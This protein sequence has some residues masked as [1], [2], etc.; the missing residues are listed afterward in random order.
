MRRS[1][2]FL[3]TLLLLALTSCLKEET[4]SNLD[5]AVNDKALNLPATEGKTRILVW[6]THSWTVSVI[7]GSKW[8]S[9][10]DGSGKND[11]Q[12]F[13]AFDAN[14]SVMR[15]GS[16][17][18][19]ADG[20]DPIDIT[21]TQQGDI[22]SPEI[23][24]TTAEAEFIAWKSSGSMPF[25][26]NLPTEVLQVSADADWITNLTVEE[27]AVRFTAEDNNTG[28]ERNA[29]VTLY[30]TDINGT[31][32]KSTFSVT[33]TAEE[34][35]ILFL[36]NPFE[37]NSFEADIIAPASI[38]LGVYESEVATSV[39]YEGSQNG[40]LSDVVLS[41]GQL[42]F[43]VAANEDRV[44][45]R[46]AT[47]SVTLAAKGI[48][49]SLTVQQAEFQQEYTLAELRALLDSEGEVMLDNG[50]FT[51]VATVDAGN[52]NMEADAVLG[53]DNID[54]NTSLRTN[55]VQ[56]AD[57]SLG[58]RLQM[59]APEDNVLQRGRSYKISVKNA[60]LK[61][62]DTPVRYTLSGLSSNSFGDN[63]TAEVVS[64][65]KDIQDLSETDIYT[66][67]TLPN[68]ELALDYGGY[69]NILEA[70]STKQNT[71]IRLLRN[72]SG[73]IIPMLVNTIA[74]WRFVGDS[75]ETARDVPHGSGPVSGILTAST[76]DDIPFYEP[77]QLGQWQIRP[78]AAGDIALSETAGSGFSDNIAV[79]YYPGGKTV[80]VDQLGW[81]DR[82]DPDNPHRIWSWDKASWFDKDENAS[83]WNNSPSMMNI[84]SENTLDTGDPRA[85]RCNSNKKYPWW[86]TSTGQGRG[87]HIHTSTAG[88]SGSH[89]TLIFSAGGGQ[90]ASAANSQTP[91]WWK[92]SVSTDD[93]DTVEDVQTVMIRPLPNSTGYLLNTLALGLTEVCVPLPESIMGQADVDIWITAAG[94]ESIDW[95]TGEYDATAGQDVAQYMRFGAITLKYNK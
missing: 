9:V 20:T 61:R 80:N 16:I 8:L 45:P 27:D 34:G 46:S 83:A 54:R 75:K 62:E 43:H 92:I 79:W 90:Q 37:V 22:S 86:N 73:K 52:V 30:Y 21:L 50:F 60:T 4:R 88:I 81:A 57:G 1:P 18:I 44:N 70:W 10:T 2:F 63:G 93:G 49:A 6:S 69:T 72:A 7:E 31:S 19:E 36:E 95:S 24:F 17:R 55:Y 23:T 15:R 68:V 53:Y 65:Q 64:K 56:T 41:D 66:L 5:L 33:Q 94:P 29:V 84:W 78:M 77:S 12:F 74:P 48:C 87:F 32:Y 51:A 42:S 11:G 59:T 35:F 13:L 67:V 91:I 47:I 14:P 58:I 39:S 25:T 82:L 3:I 71:A 85:M 38:A 26:T 89:P 76:E 28:E 40:W